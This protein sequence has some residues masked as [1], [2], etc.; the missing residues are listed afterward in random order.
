MATSNSHLPAEAVLR[1]GASVVVRSIVPADRD[2]LAALVRRMSPISLHHRYCGAKRE[3][4]DDELASWSSPDGVAHVAIAA[5]AHGQVIGIGRY[6]RIGTDS[7]ELAFDVA[8]ADQGRGIGTLL[9]EHLARIACT[10]GVTTFRA[11]VEADNAQM[12][13]V[14]EH[15][16]FAVRE[17]R[18]V[19]VY[20]IEFATADTERFLVASA[21]RERQAAAHSLRVVFSP[22][23]V[24]V[25]GASRTPRTIGRAVVENLIRDGYQGPIYPVNPNASEIAGRR[26][27]PSIAS[28]GQPIDLAVIAV[29]AC[30]VLAVAKECAAACVGGIVVL[31]SGFAEIGAHDAERE[32]RT[33]A[34][35]AGMRL[36]GPNCLGVLSTASCLDATFSPVFPLAGNISFASQSGALGLAMLDFSRRLGLGIADFVSLGNK[37]DVSVNDLLSYW[38]DDPRT[39]V[40]ALY[41]E[42]FG[43]PR[44]FVRLAPRVAR[45]RP[46]IAVKSG[47]SAAGT[48]AASSH[49][50]SLA[51]L[52]IG[53]DALFAQTGVIRTET[54]EQ[55]FDLASLL[56]SQPVPAGPRLGVV[57]NVGGPGIL[58][59]D[60]CEARGLALP[61]LSEE[62]ERALRAFLPA[63]AALG[64]PIDMTASAPPDHFAAT[65][66]LVGRD[67]NV[68]AVAVLYVPPLV[69]EPDEIAAAIARG[70]GSIPA[71]KPIMTV[72]MSSKGTPE[73][74]ARGPRGPIPSFS[75]PENVA[76]A[77]S[78]SVRYGQW[79][80][81]P[82]GT[83][84]VLKPEQQQSIR[85]EIAACR[86]GW[87][88]LE[89]IATLLATVGVQLAELRIVRP[90]PS[91]ACAAAR[92]L[93]FPCVLKAV[94]PGLVHKTDVGGVALDLE[95]ATAV[96]RAAESMLARVRATQLIVQ[97]QVP[98]GVEALVG[99]T[100]DPTLGPLLVAGIGGTAVELY[101][102]VAFRIVPLSDV[103]ANEMLEQLR[104]K[105]LLDGF[106]GAP[107]AD[108]AVLIEVIQR[109]AA[110]VEIVPELVELD[111]NPVI[112][113]PPGHGAIAADARI[114]L[115]R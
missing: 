80:A 76:I 65:I 5:V 82:I 21:E 96:T 60:A 40:I 111:L 83:R 75:F 46:I 57:T 43:N 109:I 1:D 59:A 15:S 86:D 22:R 106:R 94:A 88:P 4:S 84:F 49:S 53:I 48:R 67:P 36:I 61:R 54:L 81:R 104:G 70:A 72:F 29:P 25:V 27:Y 23:S 79:R 85:A 112:V 115:A 58:L 28:I 39:R 30:A 34:R 56:S 31:T 20:E 90:D 42:S 16:G 100:T 17:T 77:L 44:A 9:L 91:A 97:R 10:A 92:E 47:R 63:T 18:D 78:A 6:I 26:C 19:D 71:D 55:L 11:L 98:R 114:R 3:V 68:D 41:L 62:T 2:Q 99:V 108:R 38:H 105:A 45:E 50:A 110:L 73:L 93:G 89:R 66:G 87:M 102:D 113:L 51:S 74:L 8:D 52:D 12:L 107:A 14:F 35:A 13:D 24:A 37:A 95:D 64:N 69:T 32:L 7:A 33:I 103:D 101:K